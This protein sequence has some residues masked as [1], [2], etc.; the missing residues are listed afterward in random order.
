MWWPLLMSGTAQRLDNILYDLLID[1]HPQPVDARV[2]V[3]AIDSPSLATIGRWPWPRTLHAELFKH[4]GKARAV[5]LDLIFAE[6][7]L[8]DHEAD[9][10]LAAAIRTNGR[11]VLP[12]IA[13]SVNGK[14]VETLPLPG[15]VDAAALLGH[16]D[17][18]QDRDGSVRRFYRYAGLGAPRWPSFA[19]A[20][21]GDARPPSPLADR[22]ASGLWVRSEQ[23]LIPFPRHFSAIPTYSYQDVLSGRFDRELEDKVVL[24]GVTAAGMGSEYRVAGSLQRQP[25]VM[26]DAAAVSAMLQRDAIR[27]VG[28]SGMLVLGSLLLIAIDSLIHRQQLSGNHRLRGYALA[29]LALPLVSGAGLWLLDLW[30]PLMTVSLLVL[31]TG[32]LRQILYQAEIQAQAL[33]DPLTGLSNRR[34]FD[35]ALDAAMNDGIGKGGKVGL[36]IADVDFFKRYND[37]Y[38]HGAGDDVLRQLGKT[39]L[40]MRSH[41]REVAAR[42]GGEEF[43]LL[44]PD[45]SPEVMHRRAEAFRLKMEQLKIKHAGNPATGMVTCSV[46][47]IAYAPRPGDTPRLLYDAADAALY[48]AKHEGRNCVRV[49]T[50]LPE[51]GEPLA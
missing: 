22:T 49:L 41:R 28:P 44:V 23:T 6:P 31:G 5:G 26:I 21:S 8:D 45:G 35:A 18:E 7:S 27:L 12:V 42:L 9:A 25:G 15:L 14:L 17:L 46:G 38:G 48:Q 10:A 39:L 30:V 16:T 34:H 36:M 19:G 29:A 2:A 24:V 47:A 3:I 20:L 32:M 37:H 11:V 4:L 33:T 1:L 43:A 13:E 50:R 40:E 51:P